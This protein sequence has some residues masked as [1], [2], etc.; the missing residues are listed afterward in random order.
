MRSTQEGEAEAREGEEAALSERLDE[1]AAVVAAGEDADVSFVD[2][3]TAI[4]RKRRIQDYRDAS[5]PL[6]EPAALRRE[7]RIEVA[8]AKLRDGETLTT[9]E[10]SLILRRLVR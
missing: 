6:A 9:P 1:A 10:I 7:I 3:A 5:P 4:V 2:A 8:K